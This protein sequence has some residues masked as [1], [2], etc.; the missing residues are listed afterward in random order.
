MNDFVVMKMEGRLAKLVALVDRSIYSEYITTTRKGKP[1]LYV[2]LKKALYGCLRSALLFYET[3]T[4]DLK[5]YGFEINP[6]DPCVANMMIDGEQCT[7]LWH[8]D[9][10]KISH[11]DEAVIDK[12]LNWLEDTYGKIRT[13]KGK[14]HTYV[15]MDLDF[16]NDGEVTVKMS[17]YLKETIEDFPIEITGTA[18]TPVS[19]FLFT[20]NPDAE[21]L[22]ERDAKAFHT[23][24]AKL[25]FVTKRARGDI[26]TAISF[27]T[28]R[29]KSPDEDDWKKLIRLLKYIKGTIDLPLTLSADNSSILKWWADGS[30]AV[31]ADMKKSHRRN[32][33]HGNRKCSKY[34]HEAEASDQKFNRS[35]IGGGE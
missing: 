2:V 35:R 12:I 11:K 17:D 30:F 33:Q 32:L 31:H 22:N 16:S 29:V 19:L 9:D 27:L 24:V 6:Y 4:K 13:T 1:T 3:L 23:A 14:Q 25:L 5:A 26:I 21:K 8:V 28:T 20:T 7:I 10:L 15:G 18:S 34:L